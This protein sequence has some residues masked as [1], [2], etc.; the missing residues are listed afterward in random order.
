[1]KEL[2]LHLPQGTQEYNVKFQSQE[3]ICFQKDMNMGHC[4]CEE[5]LPTLG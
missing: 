5:V 1:M 4:E 3:P 2:H